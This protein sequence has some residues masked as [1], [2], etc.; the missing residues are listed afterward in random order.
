VPGTRSSRLAS[1]WWRRG[2]RLRR[3]EQP[4]AGQLKVPTA[5]CGEVD[6]GIRD[7]KGIRLREGYMV[8]PLE[9]AFSGRSGRS[10]R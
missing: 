10:A 6:L 7:V 3:A 9:G 5:G 4:N 8:W 2:S 1:E